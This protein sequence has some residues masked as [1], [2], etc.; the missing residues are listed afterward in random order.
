M[1]SRQDSS[2][3]AFCLPHYNLRALPTK[4]G[5]RPSKR[6]KP[7]MLS[8]ARHG[9]V[10]TFVVLL[11]R[12]MR[13]NTTR[14]NYHLRKWALV[15]Q[16]YGDTCV[17]CHNQPATQ[18]DHVIPVSWKE[19]NHIYN[20]R[21]ACAWCNLLAGS[22]VFG[23]FDDK[24]EWLRGE[25]NRK[26]KFQGQRTV[27]TCCKLPFQNPFHAPNYFLCAECY[28]FEYGK[29]VHLRPRWQEWLNLCAAAGFI[30]PAHRALAAV[31]RVNPGT[32][33]PVKEKALILAEEYAKRETWEVVGMTYREMTIEEYVTEKGA[34]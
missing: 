15:V 5:T 29:L 26:R 12:K 9:R 14:T 17:Y 30:V 25:R 22:Q 27:C 2:S 31:V 32:T 6:G 28:D 19:C 20:L 7:L 3:A 8:L 11:R 4:V 13:Y 1:K 24:Y 18:I 21:P 10:P 23:N 33:I 34:S 16:V